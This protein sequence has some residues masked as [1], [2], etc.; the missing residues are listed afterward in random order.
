MTTTGYGD[1]CPVTNYEKVFVSA[2]MIASCGVFAY[3]VGSIETI[4]KRSSTIESE[5]K[6]KILHVN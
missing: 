2:C 6:E 4:V 5:Y 1:I 3:V